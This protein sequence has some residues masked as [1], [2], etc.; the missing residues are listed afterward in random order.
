MH[1]LSFPRRIRDAKKGVFR[2]SCASN[3]ERGLEETDRGPVA[4]SA[5]HIELGSPT[6]ACP[7]TVIVRKS[8]VPRSSFTEATVTVLCVCSTTIWNAEPGAGSSESS[9]TN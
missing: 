7:Q 3:R 4:D 6:L 1:I 9:P 2:V 8:S 5:R